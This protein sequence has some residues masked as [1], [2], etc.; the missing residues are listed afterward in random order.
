LCSLANFLALQSVDISF[1]VIFF[2]SKS[3][4]LLPLLCCSF[5]APYEISHGFLLFCHSPLIQNI[6]WEGIPTYRHRTCFALPLLIAFIRLLFPHSSPNAMPFIKKPLELARRAHIFEPTAKQK[7]KF[8][9]R[10][11]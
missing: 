11:K 8:S 3:G 7:N 5:F 6:H 2:G 9:F 4:G 10:Y 1:P